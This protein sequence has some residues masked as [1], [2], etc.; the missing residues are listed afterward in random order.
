M[1]IAY[2]AA[3]SCGH[4]GRYKT[5]HR[6]RQIFFWPGMIK[7]VE[8]QIESCPYYILSNSTKNVKSEHMFSWPIDVPFTTTHADLWS[9]GKIE[10]N[11]LQ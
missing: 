4:M 6:L 10:D 7:Y 9:A 8:D 3:P 1:F 2:H 5:L 11:G